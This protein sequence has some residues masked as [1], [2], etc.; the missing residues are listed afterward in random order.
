MKTYEA[1]LEEVRALRYAMMAG[2]Q[3]LQ[4][5]AE[6]ERIYG[7]QELQ[8]VGRHSQGTLELHLMTAVSEVNNAVRPLM[9][10][11]QTLAGM[12]A[13]PGSR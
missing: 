10:I 4:S 6:D 1:K 7:E 11:E 3:R 12:I 8:R 13:R 5:F 2:V 9:S